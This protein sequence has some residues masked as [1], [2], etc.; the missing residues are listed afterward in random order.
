MKL[1]LETSTKLL[2]LVQPFADFDWILAHRF[3]EDEEY[4]KWYK[5][6]TNIKVIDNSVNEKGEPLPLEVMVKV[7]EEVKGTYLVS[8]DWI[9]D[10][11]KTI[12]AYSQC[13][14]Q[15]GEERVIGV[16]QGRTPLEALSCLPHYKGKY[17]AVPYLVGGSSKKDLP[18][19]MALRRQLVV[20]CIPVDRPIHLLGFTTLEEFELYSTRPNVYSVDTGVPVLLGLLEEDFEELKDKSVSTMA[21]MEGLEITK[22]AWTAICRNIA[23]FRKYIS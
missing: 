18:W 6:S 20:S 11:E 4:A 3:L 16:L 7:F 10:A 13:V 19:V 12:G 1:A 22:E 8:P 2:E 15:F 17:I 9:G 14:T 21:K 23:L 5:E